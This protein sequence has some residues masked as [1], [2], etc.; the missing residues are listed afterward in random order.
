MK[1]ENYLLIQSKFLL[2]Y[3]VYIAETGLVV[4]GLF[5]PKALSSSFISYLRQFSTG[6]NFSIEQNFSSESA[7]VE[8]N[9]L[10]NGKGNC[11]G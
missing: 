9:A 10:G 4:Q 8:D 2:F 3:R 11:D 7:S 1:T 5:S 6:R